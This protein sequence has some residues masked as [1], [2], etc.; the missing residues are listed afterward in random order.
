MKDKKNSINNFI[1]IFDNYISDI[2][3][4]QA[5]NYFDKQNHFKKT[6]SRQ[7][8]E[9]A[10]LNNK[11]DLQYFGEASN[12]EE[13]VETLKPMMSN[14]DLALKHYEN[15]TGIKDAYNINEFKYATLKIQK[16]SPKEGYHVW[17][18][19]HNRGIENSHRALAYIIYLN[20]IEDG[21]ETEFLNFSLRVKPKKGRIVIWPSG[22]PYVHRGNPPLKN[23]KYIV[24]SWLLL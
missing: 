12:L 18:L 4:S 7:A 21:G 3:C 20:D 24:T 13:W 1:G 19:E 22:F 11:K 8:F 14:F 6:V 9:K 17:H 5:I 10:S 16:T 23:E 2:D 15:E